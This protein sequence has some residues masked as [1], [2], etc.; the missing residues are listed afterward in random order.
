MMIG[1]AVQRRPREGSW[2]RP[3]YALMREAGIEWVRMGFRPPFTD[4]T[5]ATTTPEFGEQERE[6]E[7]LARHG[8]RVMGYTPFP[9]GDPDI[10]GG[11][12]AWGGPMGSEGYFAAYEEVCAWLG[13]RFSGVAGAWQVANELNHGDWNGGLTPDQ[14]VEFLKRGARGLKRANPGALVGF[15]MAGFGEVAMGMYRALF[16]P[17]A[18]GAADFDYIGADGYQAPELWPDKFAQ[19]AAITD[20]PIVVQE[21]G[22]ASAGA[23]LTAEQMATIAFGS[24]R[25][26]CKY[27]AWNPTW[28]DRP[29]TP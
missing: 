26:R 7:A 1:A 3:D 6:V 18:G 28:G 9:G 22:Y 29:H 10:G 14:G 11:Y 5:L 12:P 13:R 20:R 27:R 8:L 17:D 21:F 16:P 15:N 23:T 19:L 25:D 4:A 2:S 24:A